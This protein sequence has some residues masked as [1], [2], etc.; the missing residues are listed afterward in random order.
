MLNENL[1]D[2]KLENFSNESYFLYLL[3]ILTNK[4]IQFNLIWTELFHNM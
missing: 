1:L 3:Y 4:F 2:I